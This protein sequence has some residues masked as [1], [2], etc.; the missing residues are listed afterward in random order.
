MDST[1]TI[2][3]N[4]KDSMQ[5]Q[6][7][8]FIL[9]KIETEEWPLGSKIP[10]ERELSIRL[11]V[12]RTTV[13][14]AIQA[15]T[16]RD[17]FDRKIGQGT[18]VKR[19]PGREAI[20]RSP[21]GTLGYVVCKERS[22]RKPISSEAFYF[23]V[24]SGIEEETVRS[25]RHMLFI[26]LDDS[27]QEELAAFASFMDKVDGLVVEEAGRPDF[28]NI[29]ADSGIPT[30]LLAPSAY[31]E[32]LDIVTMDLAEGVRKAVRCL[33]AQG[34]ERIGIIN[35][36]L[37]LES[38]RVRYAAWK[39]EMEA[40]GLV[41]DERRVDGGEGW[42]AEAGFV[43]MDRL[44]ERCPDL[45]AVFCANDLLAVGAL[46]AL[47]RRGLRVPEDISVI[48]FDDTELARHAYP[49]LTTMKIYSRDMARSAVHRLLERIDNPGMPPVRVEFP[50]DLVVRDSCKE[51][52]R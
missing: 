31:H 5:S 50:I 40:S 20:P 18:F 24:F 7:E 28:L 10:S 15:L 22:S 25:G 32:K 19:K 1:D 4:V 9:G 3:R 35:G 21:R 30:V 47:S 51:V 39:D 13:R 29:L 52:S 36:P 45:S 43:A 41:P 11:E 12:S 49:P 26:Y 16:D 34:H 27:S 46:S 23:D 33:R 44:V 48:G 37:R 14:N 17:F 2:Q 42:S 8:S 38:A 6:V